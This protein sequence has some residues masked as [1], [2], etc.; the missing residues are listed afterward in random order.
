MNMREAANGVVFVCEGGRKCLA[1][2][3]AI[4]QQRVITFV[5]RSGKTHTC[6]NYIRLC[7]GFVFV[8]F[9]SSLFAFSQVGNEKINRICKTKLSAWH[10]FYVCQ[11]HVCCSHTSVPCILFCFQAWMTKITLLTCCAQ[12]QMSTFPNQH[13]QS[14][15]HAH[16]PKSWAGCNRL[17]TSQNF[18]LLAL[19]LAN[20]K[21]WQKC[22]I[23]SGYYWHLDPNMSLGHIFIS[24][25]DST[26]TNEQWLFFQFLD[27]E[28]KHW[29]W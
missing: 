4:V 19:L 11:I 12:A 9:F 27:T 8:L 15:Q 1:V 6:I 24:F 3:C 17:W 28:S 13:C 25:T 29:T 21:Y 18:D 7:F 10:L 20:T 22:W 23:D 26:A 5:P 2:F 16:Q 14:P